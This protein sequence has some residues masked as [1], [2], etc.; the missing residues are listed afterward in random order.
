MMLGH[1]QVKED[2]G[3]DSVVL[4]VHARWFDT[5]QA[6]LNAVRGIP[7]VGHIRRRDDGAWELVLSLDR[8]P[9]RRQRHFIVVDPDGVRADRWPLMK[10]APGVWD[11]P[12]SVHVPGQIHAFV[13]LRNAP[14]PAPWE[15][16]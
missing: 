6:V 5:A 11:L 10:L 3:D 8:G 7:P 16:L 4:R 9:T 12:K 2:P 13:T 14:S 1:D 15:A